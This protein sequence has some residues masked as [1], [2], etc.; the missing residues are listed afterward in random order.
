M[1]HLLEGRSAT[2][3]PATID[4]GPASQAVLRCRGIEKTEG[5]SGLAACLEA[6]AACCAA[7]LTISWNRRRTS[8]TSLGVNIDFERRAI[9]T[10]PPVARATPRWRLVPYSR[11]AAPLKAR[12]GMMRAARPDA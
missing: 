11:S 8:R 4:R 3:M 12:R 7:F 9:I 5:F 2:G 10:G 1:A 6:A